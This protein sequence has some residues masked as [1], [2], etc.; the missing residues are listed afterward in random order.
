MGRAY[1][2]L[3]CLEPAARYW[4]ILGMMKPMSDSNSQPGPR[5]SAT[6][7]RHQAA[8]ICTPGLE[9]I[10]EAEM[11]SIGLKPKPGNKGVVEFR[12]NNRQ[13]YA[14]NVWL[15]TASRVLVRVA[16]FR[17]TDFAHLQERAAEVDWGQWLV[18]G[19]APEF[20]VTANKSKLFHTGAIAQRLHQIVGPPSIGEPTQPFVVR[21]DRDQVTVSVDSGGTPLNH[22]AWRTDIGVAPLRPTMAAAMLLGSGWDGS[23]PLLDPFC[24]SG[25]IVIEAALLVKGLPPG[26][27]RRFAF[28]EWPDFE[29]GAWASATA[30]AP[31]EAAFVRADGKPLIEASDRE[32]SA[33]DATLANAARAGVAE[34]VGAEKRVVSHLTG[35]SGSGLVITNPPY[36]KR[37]SGGDLVPLYKRFGAVLRERRPHWGLTMVVADRALSRATDGT[38]KPVAGFGHGGLKV[39]VV[40]RPGARPDEPSSVATSPEPSQ[41]GIQAESDLIPTAQ[42]D[43]QSVPTE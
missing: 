33:I 2:S 11:R 18:K 26:G 10:L 23:T 16:S 7:T 32:Q 28:Q 9:S 6:P 22:R 5:R 35:D 31:K 36:G 19:F 34:V 39:L 42:D 24:G 1:G 14:A 29:P 3:P 43:P 30:P 37:V 13:L 17:A 4:A 41:P 40:S 27:E 8:A 38:L 25:T 15:R 21:L 12:A 20:R